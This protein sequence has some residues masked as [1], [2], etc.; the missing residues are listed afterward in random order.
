MSLIIILLFLLVIN[1]TLISKNEILTKVSKEMNERL[2][3]IVIYIS[4]VVFRKKIPDIYEYC[5]PRNYFLFLLYL[6]INLR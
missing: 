1:K 4:N 6:V 5:M 2:N 3:V